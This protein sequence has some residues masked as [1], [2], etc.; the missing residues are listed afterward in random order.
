MSIREKETETPRGD[1]GHTV[2]EQIQ[3][4]METGRRVAAQRVDRI[5]TRAGERLATTA[6]RVRGGADRMANRIDRAGDYLREADYESLRGDLADV[7]REHPK[8]AIGVGLGLGFLL[9]R[10]LS[11]SR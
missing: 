9:G 11:K 6:H 7:I 5:S 1:D 10:W 8:A 3:E 4:G 2:K